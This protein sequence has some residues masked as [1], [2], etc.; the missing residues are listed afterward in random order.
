MLNEVLQIVKHQKQIRPAILSVLKAH[1]ACILE[2]NL[3]E[4]NKISASFDKSD[5]KIKMQSLTLVQKPSN[6]VKMAA[7]V[8]KNVVEVSD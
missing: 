2:V 6:K 1:V 4:L 5:T 8:F 7:A 3:P